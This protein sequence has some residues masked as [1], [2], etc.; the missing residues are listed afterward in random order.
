MTGPSISLLPVGGARSPLRTDSWL[1]A[2]V[3]PST[4]DVLLA[5][6]REKGTQVGI[7]RLHDGQ[8]VPAALGQ[9]A[10]GFPL[11][12]RPVR[13]WLYTRRDGSIGALWLLE[14]S[15]RE[16]KLVE[17]RWD[18]K[19]FVATSAIYDSPAKDSSLLPVFDPVR[20]VLVLLTTFICAVS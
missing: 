12:E 17:T 1:S 6:V 8:L 5:V 2:V 9:G 19:Q 16:K 7:W 13:A 10:I 20:D 3:E 15:W 11:D 18:G 14:Q 4:G